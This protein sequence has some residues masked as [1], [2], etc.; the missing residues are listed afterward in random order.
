[1]SDDYYCFGLQNM[2]SHII[3][4]INKNQH[5]WGAFSFHMPVSVYLFVPI[6]S[7]N[8]ILLS[9]LLSMTI[10]L[11]ICLIACSSLSISQM[12]FWSYVTDE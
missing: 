7:V 6:S 11:F 3:L 5:Y 8:A 12:Y 10:C 2:R 4:Q 1:M 9:V